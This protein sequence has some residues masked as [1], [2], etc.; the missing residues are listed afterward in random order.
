M[1]LAYELRGIEYYYDCALGLQISKSQIQANK[2]TAIVG[3]NAAGKSTLLN[4]LAFLTNPS[5]GEIRFF[6]SPCEP[7]KKIELR[8]KIGYVQQNPYLF[9]DS[10]LGNVALGLKLRGV[11]KKPRNKAAMNILK[12][13]GLKALATRHTRELSGGEIQ[14]AAIARAMVLEPKVIILDEP[15]THLDKQFATHLIRMIKQAQSTKK[16][17]VIFSSHHDL[18]TR[19]LADEVINILDGRQVPASLTNL[20][21]GHINAKHKTFDTGKLSIKI[22]EHVTA[23]E[24]I[25]IEPNQIVL[26][27]KRLESTMRNNIQGQVQAIHEDKGQVQ[28][29]IDANEIFHAVITRAALDETRLKIGDTIWLSF[30]SSAIKVF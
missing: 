1:K 21:A 4:L 14:K 25:A 10:V 3:P 19:T 7:N 16:Q 22:L 17:T 5:A 18:H 12:M 2:I 29:V 30:K 23:G 13:L 26:S 11:G 8:R 6:G 27:K 20:Y 15:F 9:K 24:Y 28:V